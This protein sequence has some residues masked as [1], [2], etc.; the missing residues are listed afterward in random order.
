MNVWQRGWAATGL[1]LGGAAML[2]GGTVLAVIKG[3]QIIGMG[4]QGALGV[5]QLRTDP[6]RT[7][8]EAN[9]GV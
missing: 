5:V 4:V 3:S 9:P 1:I 2:L 7:E 6:G 8:F